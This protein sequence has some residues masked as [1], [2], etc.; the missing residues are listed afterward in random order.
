MEKI[1]Q[2]TQSFYSG[3][4]NCGPH[5]QLIALC[6]DGTLWVLYSSSGTSNVPTDG[7][8]HPISLETTVQSSSKTSEHLLAEECFEI[9][10]GYS[11]NVDTGKDWAKAIKWY[12]KAAEMGNA[13]AQLCLG[14][15]YRMGLHGSEGTRDIKESQKFYDLYIA[16]HTTKKQNEK[17]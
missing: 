2:V 3:D 1:I 6:E 14:D 10:N 7:K 5:L 8:W 12:L 11:K 15:I 13:E 16:Q 17:N 4:S 9:A